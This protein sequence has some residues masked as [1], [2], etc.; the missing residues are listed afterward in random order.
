[1]AKSVHDLVAFQRS[2][3][4]VVAVYEVTSR[5]PSHEKFGLIAQLRRA[6]IGVISQIAEG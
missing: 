1:M 6:A 5:F 2:M 4:V 3:D